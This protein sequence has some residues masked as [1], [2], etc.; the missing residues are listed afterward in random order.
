LAELHDILR[1]DWNSSATNPLFDVGPIPQ[2]F[3]DVLPPDYLNAVREFGGREGYLGTEYLRLHRLEELAALNTAY[4]VPSAVPEV[5]IFGSDGALEAFA[6]TLFESAI[7]KIPFIPLLLENAQIVARSFSD[8]ISIMHSTGPSLTADPASLGMQ[9][10]SKHPIALG[11]SPTDA[12]NRVLVP[13]QKHAEIA[14]YWNT[15]YNHAR[16]QNAGNA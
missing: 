14:R 10:H 16:S 9:I 11:G 4:D 13:P 15:V 7:V 2:P 8:L 6:F 5:V 1:N 3:L 12:K